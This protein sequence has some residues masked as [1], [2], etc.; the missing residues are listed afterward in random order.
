MVLVHYLLNQWMDFDQTC[1]DALLGGEEY[2]KSSPD[3]HCH[4]GTL[5]CQKQVFG[6]FSSEQVDRI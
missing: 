2:I 6:A 1:I 3:Y 5:K 4:I